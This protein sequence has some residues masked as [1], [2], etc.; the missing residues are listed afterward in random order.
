MGKWPSWEMGDSVLFG[1]WRVPFGRWGLR[2]TER[3]IR[4]EYL[5]NNA[6][7]RMG[8]GRFARWISAQPA[9]RKES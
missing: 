9:I 8:L 3:H 5:G 7:G 4:K 2:R 6:M 1:R